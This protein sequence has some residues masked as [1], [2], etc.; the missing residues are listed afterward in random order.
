M[1]DGASFGGPFFVAMLFDEINKNAAPGDRVSGNNLRNRVQYTE[2]SVKCGNS[3]NNPPPKPKSE[4]QP[5][6]Y[7][8]EEQDKEVVVEQV[9]QPLAEQ[10]VPPLATEVVTNV[11][12]NKVERNVPDNQRWFHDLWNHLWLWH[13][14]PHV[15]KNYPP[16]RNSWNTN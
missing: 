13:V 2:G 4:K 12:K 9:V 6:K 15:G 11:P 10:L 5:A 8:I 7:T 14:S 3:A 16:V 1:S